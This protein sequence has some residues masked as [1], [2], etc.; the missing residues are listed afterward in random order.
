MNDISRTFSSR[1][2]LQRIKSVTI[3]SAIIILFCGVCAHGFYAVQTWR[4]V[5]AQKQSERATAEILA[6]LPAWHK[7]VRTDQVTRFGIITDTHIH[8]MRV[9]R[10]D[11]RNDAPRKLKSVDAD[12]LRRFTAHAQKE[13]FSFLVHMGD[14]I[15]G[16]GEENVAAMTMVALVKAALDKAQLPI[17][18]SIGNHDLRAVTKEQFRD[19]VDQP[20]LNYA[21]D[22]GDY[23]FIVLD[24]NEDKTVEEISEDVNH[25]YPVDETSED[26]PAAD[27]D[28]NEDG[29][30]PPGT[31]RWLREQL[32]T[33]KRVFIFCHYPFDTKTITSADGAAKRKMPFAA[34]MRDLF[35]EYRV[36]GAFSGH[37]EAK[38][39]FQDAQ[40]R[41]YLFT[42]TK[43]SKTY[44]QGYYDVT[45]SA[46]V[47]DVT[48][49]YTDPVTG[50]LR[51]DD[52]GDGEHDVLQ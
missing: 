30:L 29:D 7:K 24:L 25:G 43:K 46:G 9:Q 40:T 47:P 33:E 38:S 35:R 17:Y 32:S 28:P 20:A 50:E 19:I 36:D 49:Y 10:S 15:E 18:W 39:Y 5:R 1:T 6:T 21:W 37:V 31:I 12:V 27:D 16:T 3:A 14:V 22:D 23:R 34:Q 51:V 13:Q 42:G 52:F 8:A 26:D 45:I 2:T 41:Y 11:Q 48:M 4:A 44:P